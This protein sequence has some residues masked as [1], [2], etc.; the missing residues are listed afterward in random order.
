MMLQKPEFPTLLWLNKY[1]SVCVCVYEVVSEEKVR[2][3]VQGTGLS[4][5][6]LEQ[7]SRC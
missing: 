5:R 2:E 6:C 1:S 7:I 3:S 4:G